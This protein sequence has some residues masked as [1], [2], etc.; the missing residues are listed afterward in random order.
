MDI[1]TGFGTSEFLQTLIFPKQQAATTKPKPKPAAKSD[2]TT[3]LTKTG[4][5]Y[6]IRA[7][8]QIEVVAK[9]EQGAEED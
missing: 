5:I 6:R 3:H 1:V 2:N 9:G 4:A 8:G 7:D